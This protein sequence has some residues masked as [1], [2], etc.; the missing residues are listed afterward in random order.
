MVQLVYA[1]NKHYQMDGWM[2]IMFS[3][4]NLNEFK[5]KSNKNVPLPLNLKLPSRC[6]PARL[7]VAQ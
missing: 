1:I 4:D 2:K 5:L 7:S 3:R 6:Y